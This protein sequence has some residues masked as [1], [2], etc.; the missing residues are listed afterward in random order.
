[1]KKLAIGCLIVAVVLV[2]VGGTLGYFFIWRPASGYIASFRQLGEMTA[3]DK[4]VTSTASFTPPASGEL[5]AD[6][7]GRF[8]KVQETMEQG[9][10]PTFAELKT[11]YD[12][13]EKVMKSEKREATMLEGLNALKDLATIIVQ[14]KRSQVQGLNA[15]GFSLDEYRWVR[16]EVYAAADLAL[17]QLDFSAI[18]EAARQGGDIVKPAPAPKEI[19][20]VNRELVAPYVEKLKEWIALGFFGL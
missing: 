18:A 6:L 4:Q 5:T 9:L 11:K 8:V 14:A 17:A 16:G 15:A 1:M 12:A 13:L 2:V 3:L 7:V 19:P 20:A 10:G